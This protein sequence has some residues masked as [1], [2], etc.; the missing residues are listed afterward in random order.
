MGISQFGRGT[1]CEG[2]G[3]IEG[4]GVRGRRPN[5]GEGSERSQ[6]KQGGG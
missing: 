5:R 6:A 3:Q 4:N 2:A 1:S